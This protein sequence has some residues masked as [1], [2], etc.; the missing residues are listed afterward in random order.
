VFEVKTGKV[1]FALTS[2]TEPLGLDLWRW[3]AAIVLACI[4]PLFLMAAGVDFSTTSV[5][6]TSLLAEGLSQAD[7]REASHAA[8][9]GSYTHML[10]EWT[11][12]T[13]ALFLFVLAFIRSRHTQDASPAVIGLAL[14]CGGAMDAFHVL[15]A[16]RLIDSVADNQDLIPFTWAICRMFNAAIQ[17]I[18]VSIVLLSLRRGGREVGKGSLLAASGLFVVAAYAIVVYCANLS[19]LPQ[20]TFPDALVKRPYDLYPILLYAIAAIFIYPAYLRRC[21]SFFAMMLVLSII[22]ETATQLYMA[23]GSSGLH[24]AAFNVAHVLKAF[25]Y[26]VPLAGLC[27]DNVV[28]DDGMRQLTNRLNSQAM[29]LEQA[30][31]DAEQAS[32]AKSEFLANMS[33]EIRTPLNSIVGYAE[34]LS[35]PAKEQSDSELWT[36]HLRRS[37][38][39]L[40]SLLNDV[41]DLSKIEAGKMRVRMEPHSLIE[42]LTD[43]ALLMRP[44]AT[45]KLLSLDVEIVG[46]VPEKIETDAVRLRQILVNLVSNAVKFTDKGGV[47][48]RATSTPNPGTDEITLSVDVEDTGIGIPIDQVERIFR[49]FTQIRTAKNERY[50]GT[51]LGLDI[52]TRMAQMIG[53]ELSV[54]SELGEGTT[55]RL[56]LEVGPAEELTMIA[57]RKLELADLSDAGVDT[58]E[59]HLDG[60][61]LLVVDD[62]RN[63]QRILRFVLEEAGAHVDISDDGEA[64]VAR[65]VAAAEAG[66]PYHVI[67]MDVQM[68]VMDG[69]EATRRLKR[70]GVTAPVIAITAYATTQD[71]QRS[72][73][74]G[75]IEFVTKPIIPDQ[76]VAVVARHV[77]MHGASA[78]EPTLAGEFRSTM[79]DNPRFA[80]L[81]QAYLDDVPAMIEQIENCFAD[82]NQEGLLRRVHQ[83][84]GTARSY[85]YP[86]LGKLA[87]RCQ[88]LLR[89]GTAVEDMADLVDDLVRHLK[90]LRGS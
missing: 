8:L 67:L 64:G 38:S 32:L 76:L 37:S 41:L 63:N 3:G 26:A 31:H 48:I 75:C 79:A 14:I 88:D 69:L 9:R 4:A 28:H 45:E 42:I 6:L 71:R 80:P 66:A 25:A 29:A 59:S 65:A 54:K 27:L 36:R 81:L 22:P 18:G 74:A 89:A 60:C 7:L 17:L 62:G 15:G 1:E 35:R 21:P 39:H 55:F 58:A 20:T 72:L 52:S 2:E 86:D 85:G 30:R 12:T 78:A 5:P 90:A 57:P 61:R 44:Q 83:I 16:T 56:E 40:L 43:V 19:S 49:P 50:E 51:G 13:F 34:L 10:F 53:G 73:D 11:A 33:H 68:P 70:R 24:D 23:F 82:A 77:E 84:K 87:E 47:W 46:E